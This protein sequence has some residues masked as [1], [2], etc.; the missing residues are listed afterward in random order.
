MIYLKNTIRVLFPF[1]I[2]LLTAC[3]SL[4]T[5]PR[6]KVK[7]QKRKKTEI[8]QA[9]RDVANIK[10]DTFFGESGLDFLSKKLEDTIS[11]YKGLQNKILGLEER[12]NKLI[13]LLEAKVHAVAGEDTDDIDEDDLLIEAE[14]VLPYEEEEKKLSEEEKLQKKKLSEEKKEEKEKS[15]TE[16]KPD[17]NKNVVSK[18]SGE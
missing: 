5:E 6:K 3:S 1:L 12:L 9:T 17:P 15:N 8:S 11:G 16:K 4:D 14:E 7:K 2:C 10:S 18:S 13:F